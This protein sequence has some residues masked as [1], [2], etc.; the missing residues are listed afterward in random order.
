MGSESIES[1]GSKGIDLLISKLNDDD[2]H[3]RV[4]A[5]ELLGKLGDEKAILPLY[6]IAQRDT[7]TMVRGCAKC[8][9][10][11]IFGKNIRHKD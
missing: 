1:I 11:T 2:P 3:A 8:I 7:I 5:I 10:M 6:N 4:V 9:L